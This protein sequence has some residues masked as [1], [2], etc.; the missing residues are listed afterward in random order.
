[1]RAVSKGADYQFGGK[2]DK[3]QNKKQIFKDIFLFFV[4]NYLK[5]T[6]NRSN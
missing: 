1:M 2:Y 4:K 3:F 6:F 5:L